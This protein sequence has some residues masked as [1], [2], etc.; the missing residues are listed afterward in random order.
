MPQAERSEKTHGESGTKG[1]LPFDLQT[2]RACQNLVS[3]GHDNTVGFGRLD[4]VGVRRRPGSSSVNP[5]LA[6]IRGVPSAARI[7]GGARFIR[8]TPRQDP[9]LAVVDNH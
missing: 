4:T 7:A 8:L 9:R 6:G 5:R 2:V 1:S 3:R